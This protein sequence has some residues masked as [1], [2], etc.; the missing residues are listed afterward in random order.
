MSVDVVVVASVVVVVV[1][2]VVVFVA[3]VVVGV[4]QR[5]ERLYSKVFLTRT[6]ELSVRHQYSTNRR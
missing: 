2:V 5:G 3:V 6:I 4:E 1:S